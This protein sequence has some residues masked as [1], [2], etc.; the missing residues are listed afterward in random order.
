MDNFV[1]L[2]YRNSWIGLEERLLN[3][4]LS[5]WYKLEN[6]WPCFRRIQKFN[7]KTWRYWHASKLNIRTSSDTTIRGYR[8]SLRSKSLSRLS[9]L[10]V[11]CMYRRRFDYEFPFR[12]PVFFNDWRSRNPKSPCIISILLIKS[13]FVLRLCDIYTLLHL[14]SNKRLWDLKTIE[15]KRRF[16]RESHNVY[17]NI[18][19]CIRSVHV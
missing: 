2:K 14:I 13:L 7:H 16:S 8:L 19:E 15:G 12:L 5:D 4:S 9:W 1:E 3:I 10:N 11:F 18:N 6:Y 17:V